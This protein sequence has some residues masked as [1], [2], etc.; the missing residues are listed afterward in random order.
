MNSGGLMKTTAGGLSRVESRRSKVL[1]SS[2][3][4]ML[5]FLKGLSD[6]ENWNLEAVYKKVSKGLY[7]MAETFQLIKTKKA[8]L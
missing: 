6:I 3:K 8:S 2:L 4:R 7:N 5:S 1:F